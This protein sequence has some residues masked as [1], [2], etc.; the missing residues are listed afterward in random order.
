MFADLATGRSTLVK[1]T[2]NDPSPQVRHR[3][4]LLLGVLNCPSRAAAA[5]MLTVTTN[6]LR[7][8]EQRFLADGRDGLVDAPRTGRPRR[9][10]ADAEAVLETAL[11]A[12]PMDEG[13]PVALWG[14][15]DLQDFLRCH[16]QVEIGTEALSRHLKKL[17]YAYR[18]PRHDLQHRQNADAIASAQH[19]LEKLQKKGVLAPDSTSCTW[20][21]ATSIPIQPWQKCGSRAAIPAASPP[22]TPTSGPVSS[23]PSTMAAGNSRR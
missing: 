3:A 12:S 18:R 13:Y 4:H 8:W 2:K 19:T 6:A 16:G 9:I 10:D 20:M 14:L 23:A 11:A 21:S 17:G 1:L 7:T 22:L 5:R 15:V